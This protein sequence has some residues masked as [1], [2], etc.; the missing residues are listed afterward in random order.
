M[1]A[2]RRSG[3][4]WFRSLG[5]TNT[6]KFH[7][8]LVEGDVQARLPHGRLSASGGYIRYDDNDPAA[9]NGRDVYY[10]AIEGVQDLT[11]KLY[12]AIR[13]SQIFADRGFPVVGNGA[14]NEYYFGTLTDELWRLSLG[15]GYRWNPNL[16]FK[17][18]Y[19]LERGEA[20][21]GGERNRENLFGVEA[22]FSF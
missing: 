15:L 7:A 4:G 12:A 1:S 9:G 21:G 10:Y 17:A 16:L 2:Q 13:F 8:N 6:T 19:S 18:E 3:G 22:A 20:Q 5:S 14:M 11:P